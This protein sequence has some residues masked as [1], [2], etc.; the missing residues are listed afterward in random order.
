MGTRAWGRVTVVLYTE[1]RLAEE[2]GPPTGGLRP[3]M[4][5]LGYSLV[6]QTPLGTWRALE[7]GTSEVS[8]LPSEDLVDFRS[9]HSRSNA[10]EFS[11]V[12]GRALSSDVMTVEA[13]FDTGQVVRD[14]ASDG[15][16]VLIVP[17]DAAP[18]ELR[19]LNA[20]SQVM[21][22]IDLTLE[23]GAEHRCSGR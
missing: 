16:F 19:A 8:P 1:L 12:Y 6:E 5:L 10:M 18:C 21:R 2:L 3:P 4:Q 23:S 15:L 22:R 13:T 14:A 9:G 17:V 11:I 20:D 7:S